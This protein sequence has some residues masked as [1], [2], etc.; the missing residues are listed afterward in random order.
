MHIAESFSNKLDIDLKE[1]D[2]RCIINIIITS[3]IGL[4]LD[5]RIATDPEWNQ[6]TPK[7]RK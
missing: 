5:H 1:H 3:S 2:D 6:T 4:E 7:K